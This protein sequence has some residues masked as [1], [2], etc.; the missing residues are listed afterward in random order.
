MLT[1]E[2]REREK[3]EKKERRGG[4]VALA[5]FW[6]GGEKVKREGRKGIVRSSFDWAQ[7]ARV[8]PGA[9]RGLGC[10][11]GAAGP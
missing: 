6:V 5:L 3:G 8:I 9:R 7:G 2:E 10:G 1:L 11:F 4:G